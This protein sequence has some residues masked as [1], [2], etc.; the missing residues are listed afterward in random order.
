MRINGRTTPS[1]QYHIVL[2]VPAASQPRPD[3]PHNVRLSRLRF[4]GFVSHPLEFRPTVM[5]PETDDH[6]TVKDIGGH[7]T[8]SVA[9]T[10][11]KPG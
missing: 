6:E 1:L 3:F 10:S 4:Q 5:A 7:S 8:E 11:Q 2:N 9:S